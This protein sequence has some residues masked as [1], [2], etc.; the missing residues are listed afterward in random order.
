MKYIL[1]I[2]IFSPNNMGVFGPPAITMQEFD[3]K[4]TCEYV[5]DYIKGVFPPGDNYSNVRCV[6]K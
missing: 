2:T 6:K 4:E 1:I 5:R 3:S